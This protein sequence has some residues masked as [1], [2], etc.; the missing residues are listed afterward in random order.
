MFSQVCVIPSVHGGLGAEG[1]TPPGRHPLGRHPHL[2]PGQIPPTK[3]TATKSGG[4]HPTGMYF[5]IRN[6]N[7]TVSKIE[8]KIDWIILCVLFIG[9]KN[10]THNSLFINYLLT[11]INFNRR[12][13]W[14]QN[15]KAMFSRPNSNVS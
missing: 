1:Q 10:F 9:H 3:K 2:P 5:C 13:V 11:K 15:K 6:E 4:T 14:L 8:Y 7:E 12:D